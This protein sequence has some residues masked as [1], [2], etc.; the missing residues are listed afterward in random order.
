MRHAF[1]DPAPGSTARERPAGLC[2]IHVKMV[3]DFKE[4]KVQQNQQ[5]LILWHWVAVS[6]SSG[7]E[8]L[9]GL[10]ARAGIK[11]PLKGEDID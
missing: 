7:C 1:A 9:L 2:L 11:F 8:E 4:R 5:G 6:D 3:S 10:P